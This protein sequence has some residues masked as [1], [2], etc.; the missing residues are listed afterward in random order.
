[1]T[2]EQAAAYVYAQAVAANALLQSMITANDIAFRNGEPYVYDEE[3]FQ[4]IETDYCISHN[5]VIG[6][7]QKVGD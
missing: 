2:K 6:L 3:D 7:Y 1:M 5:A 4:T